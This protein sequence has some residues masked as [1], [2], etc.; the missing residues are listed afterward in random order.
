MKSGITKTSV[1][2]IGHALEISVSHSI[3]L[4]IICIQECAAHIHIHTGIYICPHTH[5]HTPSC[6]FS[7]RN[8]LVSVDGAS[9]VCI[10][11]RCIALHCIALRSTEVVCKNATQCNAIRA[12]NYT[13]AHSR[14]CMSCVYIHMSAHTHMCVYI[15][16][17]TYFCK[18][19]SISMIHTHTHTHTRTH[20]RKHTYT[21]THT[22]THART[23][24][25]THTHTIICIHSAFDTR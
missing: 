20:A 6:M 21:H 17:L 13:L 18:C 10:A 23:H 4:Y 24:M 22:H 1:L 5:T 25:H 14:T 12:Y 15:Q 2:L 9:C 8:A 7:I 19:L 16:Y 3:A 11:L